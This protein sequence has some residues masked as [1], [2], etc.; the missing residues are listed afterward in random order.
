MGV[1]RGRGRGLVGSDSDMG[2]AEGRGGLDS[3]RFDLIR[4]C[5]NATLSLHSLSLSLPSRPSCALSLPAL[6]LIERGRRA[7]PQQAEGETRPDEADGGGKGKKTRRGRR[8]L[9]TGPTHPVNPS[10]GSSRSPTDVRAT[11]VARW[12]GPSRGAWAG[13]AAPSR[14][15]AC[16]TGPTALGLARL[17][18]VVRE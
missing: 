2:V 1:G 17:L 9:Q 8:R 15:G 6:T 7:R 14:V 11:G 18:P 16:G 10:P 3:I 13:P 12:T 4:R 5:I